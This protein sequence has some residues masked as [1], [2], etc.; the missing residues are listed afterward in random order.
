MQL[1]FSPEEVAF[2]EE[3]RSYLHSRLPDDWVGITGGEESLELSEEI[4]RELAERGWLAHSW[5]EEWGGGAGSVW[6]SVILEEELAGNYEP[7]GGQYIGTDRLGPCLM[8]FGT[9]EQK[10]RFLPPI[11][12]GEAVWVQLFSE[13]EAGSDLASLQT[14]ARWNGE[15][16]LV[17]G[18]KL[19]TS[20]ANSAT[21]ALLLARTKERSHGRDG[22]TAFLLDMRCPGIEVREIPTPLGWHRIHSVLMADVRITPDRVLGQVDKGWDITRA[23]LNLERAGQARYARTTR[24]L[25]MVESAADTKDSATRARLATNL[26]FGRTLEILVC[27]AFAMQERDELP[28]WVASALR[29]LNGQYEQ[30]VS[31]LAMDEIGPDSRIAHPDPNAP[32]G[33]RLEQFL[34]RQAP[35]ATVTGG[36]YEIQMTLV[37]REALGLGARG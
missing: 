34:I 24:V 7:R 25:E 13:R 31:D 10:R 26:A 19:W 4:C 23:F 28:R 6:E 14:S 18:E 8:A 36:S 35:T 9:D 11:A 27:A 30:S 2:R 21:D 5:P 29:I 37:A 15:A 3:V 20:Y 33:G 12:R 16:F 32:F 1:D 22:I 17:N